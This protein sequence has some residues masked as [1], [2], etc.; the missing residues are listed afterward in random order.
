MGKL[1]NRTPLQLA[2]RRDSSEFFNHADWKGFT[3]NSNF[4][5]NDQQLF[6]DCKNVYVDVNDVLSSRPPIKYYDLFSKLGMTRP[7]LID[8]FPTLSYNVIPAVPG[9]PAGPAQDNLVI[10]WGNDWSSNDPTILFMWLKEAVAFDFTVEVVM[11]VPG[12]PGAPGYTPG[13]KI[14]SYTFNE[15]NPNPTGGSFGNFDTTG[16]QRWN[17][18][19]IGTNPTN[20]TIPG[21]PNP[22]SFGGWFMKI[23]REVSSNNPAIL[24]VPTNTTFNITPSRTIAQL[25]GTP[26]IPAQPGKFSMSINFP[27]P[28]ASPINISLPTLGVVGNIL[29]GQTVVR[30]VGTIVNPNV[31]NAAN[32]TTI[33]VLSSL[34]TDYLVPMPNIPYDDTYNYTDGNIVVDPG[35]YVINNIWQ[36]N[37]ITVIQYNQNLLKFINR[38]GRSIEDCKAGINIKPVRVEDKIFILGD[39]FAAYLITSNTY[40]EDATSFIYIPITQGNGSDLEEENILTTFTKSIVI[41]DSTNTPNFASLVG[42]SVN[43]KTVDNEVVINPWVVGNEKVITAKLATVPNTNIKVDRV[44]NGTQPVYLQYTDAHRAP[45]VPAATDPVTSNATKSIR[46]GVAVSLRDLIQVS[47]DG[48]TYITL[49]QLPNDNSTWYYDSDPNQGNVKTRYLPAMRYGN[50]CLSDDGLNVFAVTNYCVYRYQLATSISGIGGLNNSGIWVKV[51]DLHLSDDNPGYQSSYR[52]YDG[53]VPTITAYDANNFCLVHSYSSNSSGNIFGPSSSIYVKG[54]WTIGWN[55]A[56][57]QTFGQSYGGGNMSYMRAAEDALAINPNPTLLNSNLQ[58]ACI[59]L[60]KLEAMSWPKLKFFTEGSSRLFC[61]LAWSNWYS[62]A[63]FWPRDAWMAHIN[64]LSGLQID[65][66]AF[67]PRYDSYSPYSFL[68]NEIKTIGSHI[69]IGSTGG[70][71]NASTISIPCENCDMVAIRTA[72][73]N[74]NIKFAFAWSYGDCLYNL[75]AVVTWPANNQPPTVAFTNNS[76]PPGMVGGFWSNPGNLTGKGSI[77]S[78]Y[79]KISPDGLSVLTDMYISTMNGYQGVYI[80]LIFVTKQWN[81]SAGAY[82]YTNGVATRPVANTNNNTGIVYLDSSILMSNSASIVVATLEVRST[83]GV[84]NYISPDYVENLDEWYLAVEDLLYITVTRRTSD[85][86]FLWYIPQRN[87]Q[88]FEGKITNLHI[89]SKDEMGI[90]LDPEMWIC[91]TIES[92]IADATSITAYTYNKSKMQ[93]GCRDG[94]DVITSLEGNSIIFP[95]NRGIAMMGYQQFM[96]TTEQSLSYITDLILN[97][98]TRLRNSLKPLKIIPWKYWLIFM[99]VDSPDM[100]L[101]DLRKG[102]WWKWSYTKPIRKIVTINDAVVFLAEDN[103]TYRLLLDETIDYHD[104][105]EIIDWFVTSQRLHFNAINNYKN[106]HA[107]ILNLM[108]E[109]QQSTKLQCKVF[110]NLIRDIPTMLME[111]EMNTIKTLTQRVHLL[112]VLELEYTLRADIKNVVSQVP[113][114]MSALSIRHE[115]KERAR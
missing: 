43:V 76:N 24:G 71:N 35:I 44:V 105:D 100:L 38:D 52:F 42:N 111:Y 37:E 83:D 5:T 95:T 70:A 109:A 103:N 61:S 85:N 7:E 86:Q 97:T 36:F 4:V 32:A 59:H 46:P 31:L 74:Y 21:H 108:G 19:S 87:V 48:R 90:F 68:W 93:V 12:Y 77:Q 33:E 39:V 94:D 53:C 1:F 26:A 45:A 114:K 47:L 62:S 96:A 51:M 110:K 91:T 22:P 10:A 15:G 73:N 28:V 112:Q 29:V 82:N 41:Y 79:F 81:W 55:S 54:K 67:Y 30:S 104:D 14:G 113:L 16:A 65:V 101:L 106:I 64:A 69:P 34:S 23:N 63:P 78:S 75:L 2:A 49:P 102:S 13:Y 72:A 6:R 56:S 99:Q 18:N 115:I 92:L 50:P 60:M 8:N 9:V 80:P 20:H 3:D 57:N 40:M 98:F 84:F 107:F 89:L 17:V 66:L 88:K 58:S 27:K 25:P 11:V